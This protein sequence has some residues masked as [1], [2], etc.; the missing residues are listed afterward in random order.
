MNLPFVS[1]LAYALLLDERDRLRAQN[2]KLMEAVVALQRKNFGMR[3]APPT[4]TRAKDPEWMTEEFPPELR[5]IIDGYESQA[6]KDSIE[7]DVRN[8]RRQGA[9]FTE[10]LKLL[11]ADEEEL[12]DA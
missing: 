4:P 12:A 11:T 3:E 5:Q 6:I 10:I 2:D 9:P 8:A 1:R 7:I